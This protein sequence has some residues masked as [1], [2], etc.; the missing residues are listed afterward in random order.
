MKLELKGKSQWGSQN[1]C[2]CLSGPHALMRLVR[3]QQIPHQ[4]V[5]RITGNEQRGKPRNGREQKGLPPRV[6][7]PMR[8]MQVSWGKRQNNTRLLLSRLERNVCSSDLGVG[9]P[10]TPVIWLSSGT[11]GPYSQTLKPGLL[12]SSQAL[13]P[14]SGFTCQQVGDSPRGFE[15]LTAHQCVSTSPGAP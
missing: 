4:V 13:T 5:V 15:T 6:V 11:L 10:C 9:G 7:C 8:P 2:A 3:K 1:A 12:A 14:G